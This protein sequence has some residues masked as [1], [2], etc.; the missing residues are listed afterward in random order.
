[1]PAEKVAKI[2]IKREA[3]YL[4]FVKGNA[5]WKVPRGGRVAEKVVELGIRPKRGYTYFLDADGDVART[6]Q[7]SR[8]TQSA[9]RR[10]ALLALAQ[11][12]RFESD[13]LAAPPSPEEQGQMDQLDAVAKAGEKAALVQALPDALMS[14]RGHVYLKAVEIFYRLPKPVQAAVRKEVMRRNNS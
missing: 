12:V 3:Q 13:R 14:G 8:E 9:T 5:L 4:Y 11:L 2:G 7:P 10:Q 6:R 1:M